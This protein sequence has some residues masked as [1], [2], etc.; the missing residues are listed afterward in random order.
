ML[1]IF[2]HSLPSNQ[3]MNRHLICTQ[4]GSGTAERPHLTKASVTHIGAGP[5]GV[6]NWFQLHYL[7]FLSLHVC[8]L[9]HFHCD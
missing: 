1:A 8:S 9:F 6:T 4:S 2:A 5:T 7:P 3:M